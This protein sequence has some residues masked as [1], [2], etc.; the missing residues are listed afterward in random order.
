[1]SALPN[2]YTSPLREV[3]ELLQRA[4]A[5]KDNVYLEQAKQIAKA[6]EH[7]ETATR[8]Y[9][10]IACYYLD[11]TPDI[12]AAKAILLALPTQ[13]ENALEAE[14]L[15]LLA[16]SY[17]Q[18]EDYQNAVNSALEALLRCRELENLYLEFSCATATVN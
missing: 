7:Q 18:T 9:F 8:C 11:H 16:R 12:E 14:R 10:L 13:P 5:E 4:K 17:L 2:L 1:M 15:Q 6:R 3:E